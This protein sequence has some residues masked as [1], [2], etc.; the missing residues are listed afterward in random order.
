M[1]QNSSGSGWMSDA[2]NSCPRCQN[3]NKYTVLRVSGTKKNPGREFYTCTYCKHWNGW[4]D[5]IHFKPIH[6]KQKTE[7]IMA[8]L[9]EMSNK[10][11][12]ISK[13]NE[14][15]KKLER[16]TNKKIDEMSKRMDE[17]SKQI[18]FL[19][20]SVCIFMIVFMKIVLF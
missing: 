18:K 1:S 13:M 4:C 2:A 12:E 9:D 6:L 8:K 19:L 7:E 17:M 3:C 16:E 11:D 5:E 10:M 14:M 15:T 20:L